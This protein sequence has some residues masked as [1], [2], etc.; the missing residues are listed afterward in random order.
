MDEDLTNLIEF[1]PIKVRKAI[2]A[3]K[4]RARELEAERQRYVALVHTYKD[5]LEL[6]GFSDKNEASGS[7]GGERESDKTGDR[8][9]DLT[10]S[11]AAYRLLS[12]H[13]R[14]MSTREILDELLRRGKSMSSKNA[15]T[16]LATALRRDARI[17]KSNKK[18]KIKRERNKSLNQNSLSSG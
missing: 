1:N 14:A 5:L 3:Y 15:P 9:E 17:T 10:V 7:S 18:W 12:E 13:H 2:E 4:R 11:E 8:F 16:I 6:H